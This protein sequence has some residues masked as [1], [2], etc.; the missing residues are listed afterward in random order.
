MGATP[1][2]LKQRIDH[3]RQ[4]LSSDVDSLADRVLPSRVAQRKVTSVRT[5][6][7]TVR[8]RVMG[9]AE[10]ATQATSGSLHAAA[11]SVTSAASQATGSVADSVSTAAGAVSQTAQDLPDLAM[12]R[13]QGNPLAAGLLAF[14]AGMVVASLL[15]ETKPERQAGQALREH[16]SDLT[17]PMT[18][19]AK[20]SVAQVK[21]AVAPVAREAVED[22]RQTATEA[23]D[24]TRQQAQDATSEV[25][26]EAMTAAERARHE[27]RP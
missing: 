23:V 16:A 9:S 11:G 4:E 20:E 7:A 2:Q 6:M 14:G 19:A 5:T 13:T 10:H 15:P 3:T 22:L 25:G 18:E 1:D 17:A 24:A 8:E 21:E 26:Q 12:T 27:V